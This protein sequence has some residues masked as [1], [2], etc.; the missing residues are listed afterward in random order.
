MCCLGMQVTSTTTTPPAPQASATLRSR[1]E[2]LTA[3]SG[4]SPGLPLATPR[5]V[6]HAQDAAHRR[7][8]ED[9]RAQYGHPAIAG[10]ALGLGESGLRQ[11]LGL[12][13]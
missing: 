11:G 6:A 9:L 2:A 8:L 12:T 13:A 10:E 1:I 7:W 4:G 5:S 3:R